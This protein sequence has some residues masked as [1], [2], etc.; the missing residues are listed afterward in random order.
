VRAGVIFLVIFIELV[1]YIFVIYL[2]AAKQP[3][4]SNVLKYI[5]EIRTAHHL[6]IRENIVYSHSA[7]ERSPQR[8]GQLILTGYD[9]AIY[10]IRLSR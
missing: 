2:T 4:S 5:Q 7:K 3:F 6:L 8:S 9:W 1:Y 10:I